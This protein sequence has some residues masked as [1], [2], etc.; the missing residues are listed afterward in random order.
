MKIKS[1]VRKS[2]S[3]LICFADGQ[4]LDIP[5]GWLRTH[6]R[7][8]VCIQQKPTEFP[9]FTSTEELNRYYRIH[10]M[11]VLGN[12][13]FGISWGDGHRSI[14]PFDRVVSE[15]KNLQL[16]EHLRALSSEKSVS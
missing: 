8:A 15:F 9:L 12:Y 6:C 5:S 11:E 13:A 14:Y 2:K 3:L 1:L 16:P 7:C 10:K 4:E